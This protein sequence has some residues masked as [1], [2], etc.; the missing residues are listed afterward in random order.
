MPLDVTTLDITTQFLL[1]LRDRLTPENW[2]PYAVSNPRD[3]SEGRGCLIQ[4]F[5]KAA[6]RS[7]GRPDSKWTEAQRRLMRA[8]GC[9]RFHELGAFNDRHTLDEVCAL[10]DKAIAER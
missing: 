6:Q 8:A 7:F 1:E 2:R 10:V 3:F 9:Q 4:Q 5:H